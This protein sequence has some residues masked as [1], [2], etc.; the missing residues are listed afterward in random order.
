MPL[1]SH[2]MPPHQHCCSTHTRFSHKWGKHPA[3]LH[4]AAAEGGGL[5]PCRRHRV[6]VQAAGHSRTQTGQHQQARAQAGHVR[7]L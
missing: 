6:L 5:P 2:D 4:C 7:V 1:S 3:Q